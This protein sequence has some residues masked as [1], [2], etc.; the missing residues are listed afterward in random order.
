MHLLAQSTNSVYV[1]CT[2]DIKQN[3][4]LHSLALY[5]GSCLLIIIACPVLEE[6]RQ[7]LK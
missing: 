1:C 7:W 6:R 2:D 3:T 5:A 4:D